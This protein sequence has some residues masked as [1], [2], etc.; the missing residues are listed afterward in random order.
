MAFEFPVSLISKLRCNFDGHAYEIF[1]K[2]HLNK[3][4]AYV[5]NGIIRCPNCENTFAINDGIL[6][7]LN[8]ASLDDESK[9]EQ[10]IRDEICKKLIEVRKIPDSW[11]NNQNL[12]E[13]LPTLEAI[14]TCKDKTVLELGIVETF[15]VKIERYR[16]YRTCARRYHKSEGC[17]Q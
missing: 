9:H 3:G 8:N 7:I 14:S 17:S 4:C 16:K 6:N 5:N 13:I 11:V 15:K 12:M 1:D 2:C 10:I